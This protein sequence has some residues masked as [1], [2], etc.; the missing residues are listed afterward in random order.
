[1]GTERLGQGRSHVPEGRAV[2]HFPI[3]DKSVDARRWIRVVR[4][5]ERTNFEF[6]RPCT[7]VHGRE[8]K[9]ESDCPDHHEPQ[10]A[11]NAGVQRTH[12]AA[13]VGGCGA[14]A[15]GVRCND[16]LGAHPRKWR[17]ALGTKGRC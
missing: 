15:V 7:Q 4:A 13:W 12:T 2:P 11:P 17:L 3:C 10:V 1:M 16:S 14:A 8:K 9:A 6:A 5:A